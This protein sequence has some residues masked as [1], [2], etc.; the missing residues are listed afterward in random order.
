MDEPHIICIKSKSWYKEFFGYE[1]YLLL[2]TPPV[3]KAFFCSQ[4]SE[5]VGRGGCVR[6]EGSAR[7]FPEGCSFSM[8]PLGSTCSDM[9]GTSSSERSSPMLLSVLPAATPETKEPSG[10]LLLSGTCKSTERNA[11]PHKNS[12]LLCWQPVNGSHNDLFFRMNI[13]TE[14]KTSRR[15]RQKFR[16]ELFFC[17]SKHGI[18]SLHCGICVP[19]RKA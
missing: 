12:R 9:S 6:E 3:E 19:R 18:S 7:S 10:W 14:N 15:G 2:C 11:T 8:V 13:S 16:M 4:V 5:F 1:E 17:F